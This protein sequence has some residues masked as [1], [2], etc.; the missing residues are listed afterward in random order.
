MLRDHGSVKSATSTLFP[1]KVSV[2][3]VHHSWGA[4]KAADKKLIDGMA[5]WGS[6][7]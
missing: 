6:V 3:D 4:E 2:D 1:N 5:D 7:E